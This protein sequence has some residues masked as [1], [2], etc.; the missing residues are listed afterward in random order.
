MD[1]VVLILHN[2]THEV[3]YRLYSI[4][5]KI[6]KH[7]TISGKKVLSTDLKFEEFSQK[8]GR[9]YLIGRENRRLRALKLAIIY[10]QH[11]VK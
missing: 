5:R 6:N 10:I 3:K 2:I 4:Y 11:L 7:M 9:D 8:E 1:I